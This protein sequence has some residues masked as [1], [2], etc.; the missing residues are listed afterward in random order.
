MYDVTVMEAC[1]LL[2]EHGEQIKKLEDKIK[3]VE[4]KKLS[5]FE[6]V[7]CSGMYPLIVSVLK[8]NVWTIK[9]LSV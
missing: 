1:T 9:L 2:K 8:G 5:E 4:H 7:A 6:A 3:D